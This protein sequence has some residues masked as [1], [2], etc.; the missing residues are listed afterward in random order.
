[1]IFLLTLAGLKVLSIVILFGI[2]Y[3]FASS[4]YNLYFHPLSRFPGPFL[5]RAQDFWVSRQWISGNWPWE[6]EALHAKYGDIVRIGPN[7]LSC[8]HPQSI[9][10]IYGQPNIN[11]PQFFRKFTTFYK[12]TDV[13]G[14][15]GTEVDP[16][17]HQGIRKR[18]APGFSVSALSKQSDIVIRHIDS[19]LHQVSR[20][21]QCQSGMNMS[22]W[23]M[24]LAFDVIVD[25]SFGEE[26]G[27]VET[28]TGN[29]W[30]NML[31]N[32]GFQIA[33][34]YVVRRRWKALQDLV[35]YCLVNEKSK[36]MRTKY[37]ANAR[38]K[39]R[40]RLERG[41]D[42]ERFDF[43]SHLLREKA[44][45]ANIDFFA[46][47]GT[48][49]VAA[50]TETTSTFMSA[51]TYYLLQNPRAL[52]R[53]QEELRRSFKHHSEIDGES[54]KS[55]KYLNAAIEEGMRIF[56]PAPFGLP[57][58]SPGAMV[59]GEWIP[60]GSIIATAAHVTSRDERWFFKSKEFHPER[61]LPLDHPHYDHIFSKDRK[62]ASKPFSIG[63]RSCIGIHL[64]YME[65]R[66]CV[67]KLAWSFDW[68]QVS[69]HEDFVKDARLLGL[70]KAAPFHVRYQPYPGAEPP[71][72]NHSKINSDLA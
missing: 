65:V 4:I 30:I 55:L 44:P 35:R 45:E 28:G 69:A 16:H 61:W 21:G 41:A 67:S 51:L 31:A 18:L 54:T 72:M 29:D 36:S 39:A 22:Q 2:I 34:G 1:M 27:T 57:R 48:T 50:G 60:K 42:V 70:W 71:V 64:S 24:W 20:N 46:S 32:S 47:Q 49:L 3:L 7:E 56:A 26:L 68:E 13:G 63:S 15:I 52:D 59:S 38:E 40:Q 66:I 19:L 25:L 5:A 23:F 14:S 12:Q 10:D 58:V 17:I 53:L 62:D 43:F 37:I 6:V 11:H 8:A 9:K 33:L